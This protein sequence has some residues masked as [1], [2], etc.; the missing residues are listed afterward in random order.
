MINVRRKNDGAK[1][2][3]EKGEHKHHKDKEERKNYNKKG[4]PID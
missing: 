2:G 1:S 3:K 4:E